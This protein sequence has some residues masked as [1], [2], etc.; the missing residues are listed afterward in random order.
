MKRRIKFPSLFNAHNENPKS[1]FLKTLSCFFG[2]ENSFV[3]NCVSIFFQTQVNNILRHFFWFHNWQSYVIH[4]RKYW[5]KLWNLLF[6]NAR[7]GKV[8]IVF[9]TRAINLL[10]GL[11][12]HEWMKCHP[13]NT[14]LEYPWVSNCTLYQKFWWSRS[15]SILFNDLK[16]SKKHNKNAY[17]KV[18]AT[19]NF[20]VINQR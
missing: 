3:F 13:N 19:S 12:N 1:T 10:S 20:F 7:K 2:Q 9:Q 17:S 18:W 4:I 16:N 6:V 11:P 14:W 5:L 15:T 8:L